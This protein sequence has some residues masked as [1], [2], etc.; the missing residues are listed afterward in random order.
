M[1]FFLAL[2]SYYNPIEWRLISKDPI[3]FKG[4]DTNLYRYVGGNPV[5]FTDPSGEFTWV[6]AG[7]VIGAGVNLGVTYFANGGNVTGQQMAAVAVSGAIAG[8]LGAAAGPLGALWQKGWVWRRT[9]LERRS[10]P[11]C[12]QP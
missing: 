3:R 11:G 10:H 1:T 2:D 4:G 8:A 5:N 6:A 12:F 9:V 7:A